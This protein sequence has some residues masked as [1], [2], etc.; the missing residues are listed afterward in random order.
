MIHSN[1]YFGDSLCCAGFQRGNLPQSVLTMNRVTEF[2]PLRENALATS[3]AGKHIHTHTHRV[4][5]GFGKMI[6]NDPGRQKL[7]R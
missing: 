5:R 6:L 7:V 1:T 3:H 2:V 4:E